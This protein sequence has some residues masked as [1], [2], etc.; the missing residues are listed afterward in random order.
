MMPN[1]A[2]GCRPARGTRFFV[3]GSGQGGEGSAGFFFANLGEV[4]IDHGGLK[5][6]VA[7]VGSDLAYAGAC[8]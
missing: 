3:L 7:E 2:Q 5:G 6:G 8:F 4:K 1:A